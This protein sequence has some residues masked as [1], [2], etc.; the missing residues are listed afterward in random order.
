MNHISGLFDAEEV[1]SD[2]PRFQAL[3]K[4]GVIRLIHGRIGQNDLVRIGMNK[5][6]L[7]DPGEKFAYSGQGM[8]VLARIVDRYIQTRM[9][10]PLGIRT[11]YVGSYLFAR[12]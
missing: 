8:Q 12:L 7:F 9:F 1:L 6:L 5:P 4:G 11:C 2:P 10:D 3:A